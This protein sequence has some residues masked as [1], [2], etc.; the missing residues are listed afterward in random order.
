MTIS[1]QLINGFIESELYL[2]K[3]QFKEDSFPIIQDERSLSIAWVCYYFKKVI[4][5]ENA[6]KI[7]EFV[8]EVY[9]Y[10]DYKVYGWSKIGALESAAYI[11][12]NDIYYANKLIYKI[13]CGH[14]LSRIFLIRSMGIICPLLK[15]DNLYLKEST[16]F[17]INQSHGCYE[18]NTI[19]YLLTQG[20]ASEKLEWINHQMDLDINGYHTKFF[21][22]IKQKGELYQSS[23]F[24][25][26]FDKA[27]SYFIFKILSDPKISGVQYSLF[28]DKK[29]NFDEL[30]N[31][32]KS[33]PLSKNY[34]DFSFLKQV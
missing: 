23:F 5:R 30:L 6:F 27:K 1:E 13:S 33:H 12:K 34:I 20:T 2:F 29:I 32:E 28:D 9:T 26:V 4:S 14:F 3:E 8:D 18:E 7:C 25:S 31:L 11:L 22:E 15:F 21:N 19:F 17:N 24:A 16:E 10:D